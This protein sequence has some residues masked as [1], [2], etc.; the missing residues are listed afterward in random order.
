MLIDNQQIKEENFSRVRDLGD[1]KLFGR[2]Y[3]HLHDQ[4]I[5]RVHI[6]SVVFHAVASSTSL[7]LMLVARPSIAEVFSLLGL[8]E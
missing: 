4:Q 6:M 7:Q 2:G 8:R 5:M 1:Q 3:V